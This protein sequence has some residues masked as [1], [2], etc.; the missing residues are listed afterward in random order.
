MRKAPALPHRN[1][2]HA[3]SATRA[4]EKNTVA[5]TF[6]P[7][8]RA[9]RDWIGSAIIGITLGAAFACALGARSLRG[10]ASVSGARARE[11]YLELTGKEPEQR[12]AAAL[13]FPGSLW[14]QQDDFAS[15]EAAA[16][17]RFANSHRVSV[18]SVLRSLDDGMREQ[19]PTEPGVT[20]V[21]KIVPCRPRL[22]YR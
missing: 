9:V 20:L 7:M 1:V 4:R 11:A 6:P 12:R 17:R 13:H 14:S 22:S 15:K 19:W 18:G 2:N 16:V 3:S 8:M 5:R 21:K 10:A